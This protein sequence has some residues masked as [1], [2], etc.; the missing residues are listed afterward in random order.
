MI[1]IMNDRILI[2]LY[3]TLEMIFKNNMG[4]GDNESI[5]SD[6]VG[7]SEQEPKTVNDWLTNHTEICC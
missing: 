3:K 4:Y 6:Y 5:D 7:S 2:H 1:M